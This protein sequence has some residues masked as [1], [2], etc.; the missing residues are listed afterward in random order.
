MLCAS[1]LQLK[2]RRVHVSGPPR[3]NNR[4]KCHSKEITGRSNHSGGVPNS[5]NFVRLGCYVEAGS[6]TFR[7]TGTNKPAE[8]E[9]VVI[10]ILEVSIPR[11][12]GS[13]ASLCCASRKHR[14]VTMDLLNRLVLTYEGTVSVRL[15]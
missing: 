14:T 1:G 8:N 4:F 10:F 15:F 7:D 3:R 9:R 12:S 6:M 11:S 13:V 2:S 5:R